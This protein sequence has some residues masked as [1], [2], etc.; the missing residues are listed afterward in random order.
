MCII[1]SRLVESAVRTNRLQ[2]ANF[3]WAL[4]SR[5]ISDTDKC[6]PIQHFSSFS[7]FIC[8]FPLESFTPHTHALGF[9]NL[10]NRSTRITAEFTFANEWQTKWIRFYWVSRETHS[11]TQMNPNDSR[12]CRYRFINIARSP[13]NRFFFFS[14]LQFLSSSLPFCSRTVA[15]CVP[16]CVRIES[17][18]SASRSLVLRMRCDSSAQQVIMNAAR[19]M[20]RCPIRSLAFPS[21]PILLG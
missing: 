11:S 17:H 5:L 7:L 6:R 4:H 20:P 21:S 3:M 12:L 13:Q 8:P 19:R 18:V 14:F 10:P 16:I 1:M 9:R 2:M 15:V